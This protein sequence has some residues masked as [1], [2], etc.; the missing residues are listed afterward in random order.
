MLTNKIA[1]GFITK[2]FDL[3]A[4]INVQEFENGIELFEYINDKVD[5]RLESELE[6]YGA[7]HDE[8]KNKIHHLLLNSY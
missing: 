1:F 7:N 5:T 6:Y 4:N 3:F 8:V 2:F